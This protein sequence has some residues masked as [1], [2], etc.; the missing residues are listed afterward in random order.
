MNDRISIEGIDK[1][2]LLAALYN[3]AAPLGLGWLHYQPEPMTTEQAQKLLEETQSFDYLH[4]RCLKIS[5]S[6]DTLYTRLYDRD[7][8]GDGTAARIIESLRVP[9]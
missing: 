2:A 5:L 8:G 1:A 4:G 9:A 3:N 7:N 6:D